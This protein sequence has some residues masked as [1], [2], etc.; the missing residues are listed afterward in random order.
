VAG[1]ISS[2]HGKIHSSVDRH[3]IS[4]KIGIEL[5]ES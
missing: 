1:Q 3:S 4:E 5:K 2:T